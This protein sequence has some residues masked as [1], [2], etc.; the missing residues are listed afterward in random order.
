MESIDNQNVDS[1]NPLC[2]ILDGV[3]G[4]IIEESNQNKYLI[5]ALTRNNK[6]VLTIYRI[7]WQTN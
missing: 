6:E 7:W 4:Y 2:L 3:D 5:F 1:E